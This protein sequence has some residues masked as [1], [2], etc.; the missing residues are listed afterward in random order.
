[1]KLSLNILKCISSHGFLQQCLW[2][3]PGPSHSA[4]VDCPGCSAAVPAH[5][6]TVCLLSSDHSTVGA[7]EICFI[8][9]QRV[10]CCCS[11]TDVGQ[12]ETSWCL[13]AFSQP[14]LRTITSSRECATGTASY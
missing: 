5:T 13:P 4:A 3:A 12:Q 8:Q 1:M 7:P 2:R 6:S 10:I 11:S 14:V 9:L